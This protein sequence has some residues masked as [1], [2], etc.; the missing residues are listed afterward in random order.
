MAP[1]HVI[2]PTTMELQNSHIFGNVYG[3]GRTDRVGQ[4]D[5]VGE[6][7]GYAYEHQQ[8]PQTQPEQ[9]HSEVDKDTDQG[10]TSNPTN[11]SVESRYAQRMPSQNSSA[12]TISQH[13]SPLMPWD[14]DSQTARTGLS[15]SVSSVY[16]NDPRQMQTGAGL[17]A[18]YDSYYRENS[19]YS[20]LLTAPQGQAERMN[21]YNGFSQANDMYAQA[22]KNSLF[23]GGADQLQ[24]YYQQHQEMQSASGQTLLNSGIATVPNGQ[25]FPG[26]DGSR[27][28][29][30]KHL[31]PDMRQTVLGVEASQIKIE[32]EFRDKKEGRKSLKAKTKKKERNFVCTYEG[33]DKRFEHKNALVAHIRV[34]TGE[35]P[36]VCEH[37]GCGKSFAQQSNL[38]THK[39]T[40]TG[41]KPYKCTWEGCNK[42]FSHSCVM[43]RHL[44]THT[45]K[46]PYACTWEGCGKKFSQQC[47]LST[48]YRTHT[49]EKPY[50]CDFEGCNKRYSDY[51]TLR[52]HKRA[53]TGEK[54]FKCEIC[55]K[56]YQAL[57]GLRKHKKLHETS[58]IGSTASHSPY[59][60]SSHMTTPAPQSPHTADISSIVNKNIFF[61]NGDPNTP[62]A[63]AVP[64]VVNIGN[65]SNVPVTDVL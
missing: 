35:K 49:G 8:Q 45:G 32:K 48:H 14:S 57:P 47:N 26:D 59:S 12:S 41:E 39:R 33:C 64:N 42:S 18:Y 62:T 10:K 51:S 22:Y 38:T 4:M 24:S 23:Y 2:E 20:N 40:H 34:H 36:F 46:K 65:V 52:V 54:P 43:Q 11:L 7:V 37:P 28:G 61:N 27:M 31:V 16:M 15:E 21:M 50:V 25:Y 5:R 17:K 55:G 6:S 58:D 56:T 53:H 44:A 13:S 60:L 63:A 19:N 1:A 9:A 3:I 29:L 30:V